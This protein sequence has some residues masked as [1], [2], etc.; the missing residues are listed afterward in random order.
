MPNPH[1][2]REVMTADVASVKRSTAFKDIAELLSARRI[3]AVPVLDDHG[4]IIGIVSQGD[5]LPKEAYRDRVPT[6]REVLLHLEEIEKAGG[7][8]AGDV[9][10]VPV[11]VSCRVVP[12]TVLMLKIWSRV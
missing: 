10:T 6:R 12:S 4:M 1:K 9:M 11:A 5:L 8:T 2:V 7:L 3:S